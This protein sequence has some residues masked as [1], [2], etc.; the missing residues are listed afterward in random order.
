MV[1][2]PFSDLPVF[3][4]SEESVLSV[5][6]NPFL[7]SPKKKPAPKNSTH[8]WRRRQDP[9]PGHNGG[10]QELDLTTAPALLLR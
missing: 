1:N 2:D 5:V 7:D 3:F 6:T 8:I 4:G 10:G 9:N